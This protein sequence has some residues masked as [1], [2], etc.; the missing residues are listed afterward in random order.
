VKRQE[1]SP[2]RYYGKLRAE[3][4]DRLLELELELER[5]WRKSL[6]IRKDHWR[7][8]ANRLLCVCLAQGG[9]LHLI[10]G[11]NGIKDFDV[12]RFFAAHPARPQPDPAI[13]R[14]K[15]HCD[16]GPSRFGKRTD[17]EAVARFPRF[18]GRNV[19]IFSVALP[20][21]PDIDPALA[22]QALLGAPKTRTERELAAKAVVIIEPRPLRIA[23]PIRDAAVPLRGYTAE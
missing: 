5:D 2:H 21:A 11:E 16:F 14:G 12:Y 23:W 7:L 19:D 6:E 3:D 18:T 10:D 9:A 8:Y 13:Y 15:T 22:I 4:L 17:A 1:R 20:V